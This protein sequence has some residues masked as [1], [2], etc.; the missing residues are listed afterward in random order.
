MNMPKRASRHHFIR[1]SRWALVSVNCL[2]V[3]AAAALEV[4]GFRFASTF[5]EF[6]NATPSAVTA[7]NIRLDLIRFIIHVRSPTVREGSCDITAYEY[8][9]MPS[10][11]VGL[12]TPRAPAA[13]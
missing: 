7:T 5:G 6:A 4:E 3:V 9:K 10:L 2:V 1:W 11:T 12:L 13:E 8:Q